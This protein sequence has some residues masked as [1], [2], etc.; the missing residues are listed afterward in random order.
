MTMN[1]ENKEWLD[2][3]SKVINILT[4]VENES[5]KFTLPIGEFDTENF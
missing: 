2:F 5:E 1:I 3:K 4:K